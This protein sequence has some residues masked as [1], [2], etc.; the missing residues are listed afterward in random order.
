MSKTEPKKTC[1]VQ[2]K[3]KIQFPVRSS[4]GSVPKLMNTPNYNRQLNLVDDLKCP[5]LKVIA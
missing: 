3:K 4:V 1:Q 5:S 2:S